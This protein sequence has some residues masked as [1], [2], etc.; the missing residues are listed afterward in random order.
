MGLDMSLELQI[1]EVRSDQM[2]EDCGCEKYT[3]WS[4]ISV[5]NMPIR[6][7]KANGAEAIELAGGNYCKEA[8]GQVEVLDKI[9]MLDVLHVLI[10]GEWYGASGILA[11]YQ[12]VHYLEDHEIK[13]IL[14]WC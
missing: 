10:N 3:E 4:S 13:L 12:D 1:R 7:R 14:T 11:T 5:A 9:T 2:V 8:C 6:G